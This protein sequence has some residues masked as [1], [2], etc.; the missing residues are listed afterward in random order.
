M[1][2]TSN[3]LLLKPAIM[4]PHSITI[5]STCHGY[6][7]IPKYLTVVQHQ[8]LRLPTSISTTRSRPAKIDGAHKVTDGENRL[9]SSASR[10]LL[11]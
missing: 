1:N 11:C 5:T 3:F 2:V 8:K 7:Q 10:S 4:V 6:L 9:Q